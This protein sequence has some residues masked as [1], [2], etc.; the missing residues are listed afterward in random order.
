MSSRH[1]GLN[2]NVRSSMQKRSNSTAYA[3]GQ[4]FDTDMCVCM[5][6]AEHR[7]Q[8]VV[9]VTL[10]TICCDANMT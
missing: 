1:E 5:D 4:F 8:H 3:N 2:V 10:S 9:I 7:L 6:N